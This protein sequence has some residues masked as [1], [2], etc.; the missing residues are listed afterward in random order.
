MPLCCVHRDESVR[1][2][3]SNIKCTCCAHGRSGRGRK[4]EDVGVV[5]FTVHGKGRYKINEI[6][7]KEV[8][9]G[10][11]RTGLKWLRT[12]ENGGLF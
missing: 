6:D 7:I 1:C 3:H 5:T 12:G 10:C 2:K 8:R 11:V 4:E 9:W